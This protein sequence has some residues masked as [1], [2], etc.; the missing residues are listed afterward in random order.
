L[1]EKVA[2]VLPDG[3]LSSPKYL[4]FE[5][6]ELI[7]KWNRSLRFGLSVCTLSKAIKNEI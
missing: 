5:N 6:Y 3:D 1:K 4:V 7:L 2:L